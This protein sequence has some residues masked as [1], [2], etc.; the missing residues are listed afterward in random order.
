M[1]T[2]KEKI[3]DVFQKRIGE[4]FDREEIIDLV[5]N[6]YP[7]T[8]RGG[9]IPS[10]YCYNMINAGINFDFH[11]FKS[12]GVRE[13]RYQCIGRKKPYTG[14]IYWKGEQVGEWK[15]GR[16]LLRKNAPQRALRRWGADK[17]IDP[18][19]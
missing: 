5:V 9:V 11:I 2:I 13:G 15:D 19:Q 3:M 18:L 4:K 6:K 1:P 14:A 8:N 16:F 12:L 10:D 7:G 17:F